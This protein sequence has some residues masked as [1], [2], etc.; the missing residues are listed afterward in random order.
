[1]KKTLMLFLATI[2]LVHCTNEEDSTTSNSINSTNDVT[3]DSNKVLSINLEMDTDSY[4]NLQQESRFAIST[5]AIAEIIQTIQAT[6]GQCDTPWPSEFN[7]YKANIKLDGH[8]LNDVGI[9]KKGFFGSIF[10]T[11]PSFKIKTD[12][13]IDNQKFNTT[14]RITLNNNAEDPSKILT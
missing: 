9:R 14:E 2:F 1:M 5:H 6:I 11:T 7:W 3:F 4:K 10:S 8:Q 12:K 13:Y